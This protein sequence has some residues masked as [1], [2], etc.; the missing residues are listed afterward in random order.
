M[1]ALTL[2]EPGEHDI[3]LA[4]SASSSLRE[5]APGAPMRLLIEVDG[6]RIELPGVAA[7]LLRAVMEHIAAGRGISIMPIGAE[8][9]TQQ[10]ADLLRVSRPFVVKLLESGAIPHRKV[11]RHRRVRYADLI[12]YRAKSEGARAEAL[13]ELSG[14]AQEMGDYD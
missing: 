11:G 1:G 13:D 12:A 8:L 9:T 10:A 6:E 7:R 2:P 4:R 3:R 14:I 5:H